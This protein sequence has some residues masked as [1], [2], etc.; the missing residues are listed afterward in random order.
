MTLVKCPRC[1]LNYISGNETIC[2]VCYREIHGKSLPEE[3][4]V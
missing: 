1:E 4:E 3:T 2:K